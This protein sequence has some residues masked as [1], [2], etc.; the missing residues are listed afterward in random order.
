MKDKRKPKSKL[1]KKLTNFELEQMTIS[2]EVMV[3]ETMPGKYAHDF[4]TK[5]DYDIKL[6]TTIFFDYITG[7]IYRASNRRPLAAIL[8]LFIGFYNIGWLLDIISM[9]KHK[10]YT[11]LCKRK[12]RRIKKIMHDKLRD[13]HEFLVRIDEST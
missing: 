12:N 8:W 2:D 13:R 7:F 6:V 10:K 4:D 11:H 5:V 3:S 1:D 9:V